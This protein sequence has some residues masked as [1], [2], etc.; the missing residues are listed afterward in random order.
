MTFFWCFVLRSPSRRSRACLPRAPSPSAPEPRRSSGGSPTWT[1][2]ACGSCSCR[3]WTPPLSTRTRRSS[4]NCSSTGPRTAEGRPRRGK[5]VRA[6]LAARGCWR[7]PGGHRGNREGRDPGPWLQGTQREV[8]A[9]RV[10]GGGC[11]ILRCCREDLQRSGREAGGRLLPWRR[12]GP[13]SAGGVA[14]GALPGSAPPRR[15]GCWAGWAPLV[16]WL[17][18]CRVNK[19]ASDFCSLYFE[20]FHGGAPGDDSPRLPVCQPLLPVG[21][22]SPARV[23]RVLGDMVFAGV[24]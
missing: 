17:S 16:G 7:G 18:T 12:G 5:T 20:F 23:S 24:A 14:Q 1:A 3:R 6:R 10:L 22:L 15:P 11:L 8:S 2:T 13:C 21:F 9:I 19:S 4:T